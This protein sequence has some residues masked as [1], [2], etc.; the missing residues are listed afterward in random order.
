M[1]RLFRLVASCPD[2]PGLIEAVSGFIHRTG[3]NSIEAGQYTDAAT[4][5]FYMRFVL[6]QQSAPGF[7]ENFKDEFKKVARQFSMEWRIR[8]SERRQRAVILVSKQSHCLRD[9]LYRWNCGDMDMDVVAVVSNHEVSRDYVEW[10]GIPFHHLPVDPLHKA[11]HVRQ[12]TSLLNAL[13]PDV[14]VLA[15]FMQILPSSLCRQFPNRI[16][17]IHHS[18]LPSFVGARPYHQAHE[19]GVKLT[20]ATCHYVTEELDQGP[21]IEQDVARLRHHQSIEEIIRLGKDVEKSVLATGLRYHL[22]DRVITHGRK[23]VVFS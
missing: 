3:A 21:I 15:R 17:N 14:I 10:H 7:V 22:E 18:F 9:L 2:A 16:I 23:T 4:G 12:L 1:S 19:R 6:E 13:S 8:D 20:G 11:D 5:W